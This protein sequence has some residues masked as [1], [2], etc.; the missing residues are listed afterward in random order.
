MDIKKFFSTFKWNRDDFFDGD[1][2]G[3]NNSPGQ[4]ITNT[5][6]CINNKSATAAQIA[7]DIPLS[8]E[9]FITRQNIGNADTQPPKVPPTLPYARLDTKS[10]SSVADA[11]TNDGNRNKK[12]WSSVG[13]V[14]KPSPTQAVKQP[15]KLE[16]PPNCYDDEGKIQAYFGTFTYSQIYNYTHCRVMIKDD[17]NKLVPCKKCWTNYEYCRGKITKTMKALACSDCRKNGY[18]DYLTWCSCGAMII[19]G[20]L[21]EKALLRFADYG[22]MLGYDIFKKALIFPLNKFQYVEL[23]FDGKN[24]LQSQ[25]DAMKILMHYNRP[26]EKGTD[27]K[28]KPKWLSGAHIPNFMPYLDNRFFGVAGEIVIAECAAFSDGGRKWQ[29]RGKLILPFPIT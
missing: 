9:G 2:Q 26:I 25:Q 18:L 11:R 27:G 14:V 12:S 10:E 28:F 4:F 1:N 7:D 24:F 19:R 21:Y 8:S 5:N 22:L 3:K 17:G 13:V 20:G 16:L 23:P 29:A 6:E 15:R